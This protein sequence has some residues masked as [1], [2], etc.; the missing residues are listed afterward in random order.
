MVYDYKHILA[1]TAE[2]I[3]V[4]M[5]YSEIQTNQIRFLKMKH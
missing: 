1:S 4:T 3:L 5:T 2:M